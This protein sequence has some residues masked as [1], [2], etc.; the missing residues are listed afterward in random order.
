MAGADTF[1]LAFH[2][3]G[4]GVLSLAC[5]PSLHI[6]RG[7]TS[8]RR[9]GRLPS[10]FFRKVTSSFR[11]RTPLPEPTFKRLFASQEHSKKSNQKGSGI[12]FYRKLFS[13]LAALVLVAGASF[14]LTA[15][16]KGAKSNDNK[17]ASEKA[18]V[19]VPM[20]L[21]ILIQDDLISRVGSE[22][23]VTRD[24]IRTLPAGSQVM[25]GYITSGTLQVRQPFT[26]DLEKAA[27]A[28]RIPIGST[29]AS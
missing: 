20:N 19:Q 29:S 14:N 7:S 8:L 25:V 12:M 11:L 13:V 18:R 4:A 28:L 3:A 1:D 16:A 17:V 10:A 5:G 23:G 15:Y 24:F 27:K 6:V 26:G 21:A 22:L 9:N 2:P